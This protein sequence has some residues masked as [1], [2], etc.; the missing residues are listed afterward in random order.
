MSMTNLENRT[1]AHVSSD[2]GHPRAGRGDDGRSAPPISIV[3]L[4]LNEAINI[5]A[6]LASCAW[7]DDIHVLDSGSTD[8][9][10]E[11]AGRAGVHVHAHAFESFGAQ[12]NWAIDHIP[13]KHDWVFHLDADER[14]TP[15]LAAAIDERLAG[16]PGEAGFCIPEKLM[17][18][19]RWLA[20]AGGYPK[21]Q[22]RL[23]HKG[24][25]RFRDYGHG[26]REDGGGHLGR[27]DQPYVHFAFSKGLGDWIDK[28]N[29]YSAIE[30]QRVLSGTAEPWSVVSLWSADRLGR[31]RAWKE[32]GA[33]LPFRSFARWFVTLFVQGGILEGRAGRTYA[34]LMAMYEEMISLKARL[35]QDRARQDRAAQKQK[36]PDN[37]SIR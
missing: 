11:M 3:I 34:R 16:D 36:N 6:C 37:D 12:R 15:E 30:A 23:F 29:R 17:F 14:F 26:Q 5:N 10:V 1:G 2:A 18:M 22:M 28:H 4:T 8:A 35:L 21:Y 31:R 13:L 33:L 9:T 20:R 24:R 32:L 25:M 7:C 27:V 19:D